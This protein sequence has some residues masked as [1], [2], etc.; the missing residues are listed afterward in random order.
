MA[1]LVII[2]ARKGSKRLKHKN[3]RAF[4]GKPLIYWTIQHALGLREFG[5]FR[6][7]EEIV[8]T[9]DWDMLLEYVS[10][11]PVTAMKRNERLAE[12][13]T[14]VYDVIKDVLK[15]RNMKYDTSILLL[16][17][18][19]PLRVISDISECLDIVSDS[20]ESLC[21]LVEYNRAGG[22]IRYKR[23]GAIYIIETQ[24]LK[25]GTPEYKRAYIMPQER[26]IDINSEKDFKDAEDI[27]SEL[28]SGE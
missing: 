8:V 13:D 14:S 19:S 20:C 10:G 28:Q 6:S 26:S 24:E 15:Q 22:H 21:S 17:P 27:F 2:P 25:K 12:D 11:F 16:Q 23:N 18:T 4:C 9:S 3:M 1:E 7:K 5:L